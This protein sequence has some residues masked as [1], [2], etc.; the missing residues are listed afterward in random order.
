M[1]DSPIR[2]LIV[3]DIDFQRETLAQAFHDY[4][5]RRFEAFFVPHWKQLID[6]NAEIHRIA[7]CDVGIF[8]LGFSSEGLKR[9]ITSTSIPPSFPE[10]I[11]C[12]TR[13]KRDA[14]KVVY[15]ANND[16]TVVA[17]AFQYGA[18]AYLHKGHI[19][20]DEVPSEIDVLLT[21]HTAGLRLRDSFPIVISWLDDHREELRS[22]VRDLAKA[23][24]RLLSPPRDDSLSTVDEQLGQ[25][26][27]VAIILN[28]LHE[29]QIVAIGRTR[30]EALLL[31]THKKT[32]AGDD[33]RGWPREPFLHS[34]RMNL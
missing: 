9:P 21:Q 30:L 19:D 22:R 11:L 29:V 1:S 15:S 26:W 8:D 31:Y 10:L 12:A 6:P 17:Q 7:P 23:D 32:E 5:A 20:P 24:G 34:L 13:L 14:L 33:G 18:S 27:F 28:A 16:V 4:E 2:V 25:E 3:E